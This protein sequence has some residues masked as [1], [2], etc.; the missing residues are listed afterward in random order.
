MIPYEGTRF[1]LEL[2]GD[3]RLLPVTVLEVVHVEDSGNR[4]HRRVG[5][6]VQSR[7]LV[8]VYGVARAGEA[9][10]TTPHRGG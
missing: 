10:A 9:E 1:Q 4:E 7:V 5:R 3:K 6:V 8:F 2:A